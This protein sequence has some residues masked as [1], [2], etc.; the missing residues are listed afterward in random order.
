MHSYLIKCDTCGKNEVLSPSPLCCEPTC[1]EDCSNTGLKLANKIEPTCVCL[2]GLVRHNRRCIRKICCPNNNT[3]KECKAITSTCGIESPTIL[4]KAH[5][6]PVKI[7]PI[8]HSPH[9][10]EPSTYEAIDEQIIYVLDAD[11]Y[12]GL[13]YTIKSGKRPDFKSIALPVKAE[14]DSTHSGRYER[15]T[16]PEE[17]PPTHYR[18]PHTN[19]PINK[20]SEVVQRPSDHIKPP[21]CNRTQELT[22]CRPRCIPTCDNDCSNVGRSGTIPICIAELSCACIAGYVLHDDRCIRKDKCPTVNHARDGNFAVPAEK[23]IPY[24]LG[25]P[26]ETD[27]LPEYDDYGKPSSNESDSYEYT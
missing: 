27:L 2:P 4:S 19:N 16:D 21:K 20:A 26:A 24:A 23:R 5:K 22:F 7:K 10:Q 15:K 13:V 14:Y 6:A 1:T 18:Y 9:Q 3:E 11:A 25:S 12:P 8:T 17:P